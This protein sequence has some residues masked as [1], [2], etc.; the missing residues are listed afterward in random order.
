[1]VEQHQRPVRLPDLVLCDGALLKRQDQRR[2][3]LVHP[4]LEAALVKGF[5]EGADAAAGA[6]PGYEAC[7][8]LYREI[9]EVFCD[10]YR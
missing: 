1:M 6:T 9:S 2:L 4:G 10:R 8:A 7:S 3:A 5:A